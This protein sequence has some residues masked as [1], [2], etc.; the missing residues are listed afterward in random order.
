MGVWARGPRPDRLDLPGIAAGMRPVLEEWFTAHIKIFDP[1]RLE[2]APYNPVG[3]T[4][5]KATQALVLDTGAGGAL[6]QPIRSPSRV[7]VGGQGNGVL[8][9]RFQVATSPAPSVPIRGGLL[10]QVVD[11]GNA[12]IPATWR[13]ALAEGIDS[14][15]MWDRIFDAT[16][17][18]GGV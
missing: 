14:S 15:L 18:T 6:I 13:F 4:G 2:A 10:I 3:D 16:L 12:I 7:D 11:G 17:V 1:K 9:I 5:G 8:G